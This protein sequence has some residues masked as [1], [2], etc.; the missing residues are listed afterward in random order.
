M[1]LYADSFEKHATSSACYSIERLLE[2]LNDKRRYLEDLW[3][4]RKIKLEQ[5]IQ[6]CYLRDEIKKV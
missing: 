5:C 4:Q 6:I 1:S 2:L 3:N